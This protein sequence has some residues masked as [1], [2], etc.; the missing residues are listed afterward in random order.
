MTSLKYTYIHEFVDGSC[1]ERSCTI[2]YKYIPGDP[3]VRTYPNGDPGYPPQ[4]DEYE[5]LKVTYDDGTE[6]DN[7]TFYEQVEDMEKEIRK[8]EDQA[9]D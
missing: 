7:E 6:M 1:E 5:I 8:F 3:G 4:D 2:D 9:Y